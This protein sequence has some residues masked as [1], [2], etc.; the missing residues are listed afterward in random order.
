VRVY[1]GLT[2]A[3]LAAVLATAVLILVLLVRDEPA[4]DRTFLAL[5]VL[6]VLLVVQVV[7]GGVL[8]AGTDRDVSG[9]LFVSY[10]VGIVLAL[11]IGV[12]WS[13]VE[14][15]RAGTAVLLVA[16]LTVAA[17]QVRLDAIWGGAGA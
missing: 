14:R 17:L 10:L 5:A 7:V 9:V 6:E 15:T 3:I 1:D 13:L 8:L 11:P 2:W 12:F 16:V 4:G